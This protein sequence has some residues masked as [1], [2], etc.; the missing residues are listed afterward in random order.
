MKSM[1]MVDSVSLALLL[2]TFALTSGLYAALPPLVPTHFDVHG[3]A[4]GWMPREAGAW[5]L[6]SVGALSWGLL[7]V[8]GRLVPSSAARGPMGLV[9]AMVVALMGG[10]QCVVLHA[11]IARPPSVGTPLVVLL[12]VFTLALG[13]VLPRVRRNRWVGV[14]TPW[15]LA[16]DENWARTHRVAGLTF[17][18]GGAVSLLAAA[19]GAVALGVVAILASSLAP[20]LYSYVLSRRLSG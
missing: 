8:L 13:L 19:S 6:P 7:W 9:A 11:A 15:T 5:L 18:A 1:R 14:R 10:L 12:G 4:D 3:V 16:S 20:V 17:A 2:G